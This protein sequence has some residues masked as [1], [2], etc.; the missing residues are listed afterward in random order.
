MSTNRISKIAHIKFKYIFVLTLVI[1]L[2][3]TNFNSAFG[4]PGIPETIQ[5]PKR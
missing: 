5:S 2:G 4:L 3:L 1:V